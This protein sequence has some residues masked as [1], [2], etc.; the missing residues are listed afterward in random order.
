MSRTG[1]MHLYYGNGKGKTTA[2]LG[3]ALRASGHRQAV[4][5]VQFLKSQTSGELRQLATLPEVLVLRGSG[6]SKFAFAMNEEEKAQTRQVHDDNL[7]TAWDLVSQ[8][9]CD[10]LILDEAL[11]AYQLGLLDEDLF[12]KVIFERPEHLEL[13]ITGHKPTAWVS[14]AADYVTEIVKH[15]HPYDGGVAGREGIEY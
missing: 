12:K 4:V 6:S 3:L 7:R 15:K 9:A 11:D 13:V 8:G 5:I 2:A 1:L 10:L 14:Q